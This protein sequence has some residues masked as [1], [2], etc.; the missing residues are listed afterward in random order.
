MVIKMGDLIKKLNK[1]GKRFI[2]DEIA[3][4][5]DNWNWWKGRLVTRVVA[6]MLFRDNNGVDILEED[7]DNLIILDVCR[8]DTFASEIPNWSIEGKLESRISQGASTDQFL[9]NN[10]FERDCSDIVYITANPYVNAYF[11]NEFCR[12][13][14]VWDFG[15]SEELNTVHPEQ[16]YQSTLKQIPKYKD[17]RFIVHFLQPHQPYIRAKLGGTGIRKL[18]KAV[19]EGHG[20]LDTDDVDPFD[21]YKQGEITKEK[22]I[23]EYYENLRIALKYT[24][25]LCECLSGKTVITADH[26]EAFGESISR[27]INYEIYGHPSGFRI[28]ELVKVPWFITE[29]KGKD[30]EKQLIKDRVSSLKAKL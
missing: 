1:F 2:I 11:S 18:R 30:V 28:E 7:W 29:G 20:R 8:Y 23:T 24:E 6:P 9:I 25:K 13:V 26:G 22:L 19:M 21:L 17:K 14:S 5:W 10:F 3:E 12:I 27:W 16:V 4:N 15:W